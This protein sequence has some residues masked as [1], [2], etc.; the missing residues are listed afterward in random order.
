MKIKLHL[1]FVAAVLSF[2]AFCQDDNQIQ[3]IFRN[4]G[5]RASGGYG[6]IYNKFT[7]INGTY[8][9]V[10]EVY[11]GWYINHRFLI[12]LAG[13]ATTN[14]L[15]VPVEHRVEPDLDLSYEYGQCGLMTEYVLSSHRAVHVAF[16]L[17]AGSG[18]TL[19]YERNKI[20]DQEHWDQYH[21]Y[22]HD[23][24]WFFV[25]E[26]GV[27]LE[28]NVFRWMRFSPGVSYRIAYGSE[29]RGL[30]DGDLSGMSVNVGLK[31]GKF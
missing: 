31:F 6:A 15:P 9:N 18:F 7:S 21:D 24:N 1:L 25:A 3:T 27:K 4:N 12:G 26:P 13:A 23:D 22:D 11:G 29:G 30:D 5:P 2:N 19:Q 16:Q 17:F 8:A 20:E 28:L 10:A 14:N